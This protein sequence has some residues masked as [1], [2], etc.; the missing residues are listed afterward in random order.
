MPPFLEV[1]SQDNYFTCSD[2]ASLKNQLCTLLHIYVVLHFFIYFFFQN[3]IAIWF[4]FTVHAHFNVIMFDV[5]SKDASVGMSSPPQPF[6]SREFLTTVK[7][8]LCNSQ[9][10]YQDNDIIIR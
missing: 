2:V 7:Q 10:N 3:D 9:G 1:L 5:D 6:V 8:C 4:K